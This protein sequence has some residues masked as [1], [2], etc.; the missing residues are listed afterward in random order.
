MRKNR[1]NLFNLNPGL[2]LT[3]HID[4][5]GKPDLIGFRLHSR[6]MVEGR[7]VVTD[8]PDCGGSGRT[9]TRNESGHHMCKTCSG[10]GRVR[11]WSNME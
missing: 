10:T 6:R 2:S 4:R 9:S 8:C 11:N 5:K 1:F 3:K 7:Y